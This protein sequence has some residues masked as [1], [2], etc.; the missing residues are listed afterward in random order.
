MVPGYPAI[1]KS[2]VPGYEYYLWWGLF[3]P[4]KLP[5]DRVQAINAAFNKALNKPEMKEFLAKQGVEP[6]PQP[7]AEIADLLP[8][9][10]KRYRQIA[11]S[12]GITPQ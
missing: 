3:A 9:E 2:G 4:A 1:A 7:A 10:I 11:K 12:A 5:A 6:T 8:R